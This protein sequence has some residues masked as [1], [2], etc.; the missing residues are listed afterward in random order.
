[1]LPSLGCVPCPPE[2]E[3]PVRKTIVSQGVHIVRANLISFQL[4]FFSFQLKQEVKS[5]H[6]AKVNARNRKETVWTE[7]RLRESKANKQK[8]TSQTL[9]TDPNKKNRM[10]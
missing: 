9:F 5:K 6:Q 7:Y 10:I 8:I 4:F 3:H 2:A 1:M